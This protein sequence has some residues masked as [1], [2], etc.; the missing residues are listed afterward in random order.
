MKTLASIL[1]LFIGLIITSCT[2]K[3]LMNPNVAIKDKSTGGTPGSGNSFIG[4]IGTDDFK[5]NATYNLAAGQLVAKK[6]E[7]DQIIFDLKPQ[8]ENPELGTLLV[9]DRT[10]KGYAR[11]TVKQAGKPDMSTSGLFWS[12]GTL[13]I[14]LISNNK[15][16]GTCNV[17]FT[18]GTS[19]VNVSG[20][21][22]D[23]PMN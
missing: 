2:R 7:T 10:D 4:K 11:L 12:I 19:T 22:T 3:D 8:Y 6:S 14:Q 18:V 15:M 1:P 9:G 20:T 13:S 16:S 23:V 21:F 5:A 17:N